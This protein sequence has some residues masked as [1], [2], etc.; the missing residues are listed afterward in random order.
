MAAYRFR[1]PSPTF[2]NLLGTASAPGGKWFF[3]ELGTSTPKLTFQDYAL[4]IPNVNPIVLDSNS[5]FPVPVWLDGDYTVELKA[6]DDSSIINPTDIRPEVAPGLAIPDPTGHSGEY[7]TNDGVLVQWSGI[8]WNLPD[9]TGSAG[10]MIVVNSDGTDYILQAQPEPPEIP[11]PEIVVGTDYFRAGVS[12]D[13]TKFLIK[14]GSG[15][16]A[17]S[18]ST[19]TTG[20]VVFTEAYGAIWRV[21]CQATGGGVTSGGH[22]PIIS[23][24]AKS[25]TGFSVSANVNVLSPGGASNITTPVAFDWM[26]IGTVEVT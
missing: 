18:G 17:A 16:M 9:P 22:L 7:L 6:S 21:F 3:Y 20:S 14:S 26:A 25:P 23:V 15:S 19:G 24:T 11:D 8:V 2:E 4:T 13:A 5:R 1:D 10:Y 12:D